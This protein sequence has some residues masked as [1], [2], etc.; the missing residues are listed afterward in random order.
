M[1]EDPNIY[2]YDGVYDAMQAERGERAR[3]AAAAAKE[4]KQSSKYIESLKRVGDS[5]GAVAAGMDAWMGWMDG[6]CVCVM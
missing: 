5:G 4:E 1:A 6:S 2:D 3:Q